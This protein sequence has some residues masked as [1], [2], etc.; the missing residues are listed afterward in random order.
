MTWGE[1]KLAAL[2]RIFSNDGTAL[3]KDDSN[4]EYLNAMPAVSPT[5]E[6][7]LIQTQPI[8]LTIAPDLHEKNRANYASCSISSSIHT[9]PRTPKCGRSSFIRNG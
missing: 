9:S 1:V 6:E 4:E 8:E 7:T 3:N 2:Q 5:K